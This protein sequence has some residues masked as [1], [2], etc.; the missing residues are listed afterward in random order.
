MNIDV[1]PDFAIASFFDVGITSTVKYIPGAITTSLLDVY[2]N[3]ENML[4]IAI[5]LCPGRDNRW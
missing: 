5:L 4:I 3:V 2:R 1:F